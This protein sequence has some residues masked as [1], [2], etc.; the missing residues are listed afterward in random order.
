MTIPSGA[1]GR[2]PG[3]FL[4]ERHYRADDRPIIWPE[5]LPTIGIDRLVRSLATV[6]NDPVPSADFNRL[7]S[8]Q[9]SHAC[10]EPLHR[11]FSGQSQ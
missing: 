7:P 4:L 9:I 8:F 3:R 2:K 6:L 5:L 10:A 11:L 1:P